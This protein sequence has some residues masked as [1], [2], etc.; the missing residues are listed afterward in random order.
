MVLPVTLTIAAAA[1]LLNLWLGLRITAARV[2]DKVL[3]GDGGLA[4]M[5]ARMRAHANFAEYAPFVL[6]LLAL[7]ELAGGWPT[8]L[9]IAGALF[10]VARVAHAFGMDRAS[11][12][13]L[14]AGGALVTWLVLA[15]LAGWALAI[16][17]GGGLP[18][19]P[20]AGVVLDAAHA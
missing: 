12:N 20:D 15:A 3:V 18:A 1:A 14:R 16:A 13:P 2:R 4:P 5:T 7:V 10:V 8:G 9:W 6:I 17:L 11:A 19:A